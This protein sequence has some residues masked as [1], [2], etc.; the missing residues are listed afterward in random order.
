MQLIT[1]ISRLPLRGIGA[2][3]RNGNYIIGRSEEM[4]ECL[5]IAN[6][7]KDQNC[8]VMILGEGGTGKEL[9]AKAIHYSG[10]RRNRPFMVLDGGAIAESLAESE[11]LGI[12]NKVATDVKGRLGKFE[13]AHRGTAFLDEIGNLDFRLQSRL[14]RVTEEC[15]VVRVGTHSPKKLDF[16][17]ISATN[18]DLRR[19]VRDGT[20]REDLYY[21]LHVVPIHIPP[22]RERKEDI[23]LLAEYF[24]IQYSLANNL[25]VKK[26]SPEAMATLI[27]YH[28]PGNVRELRNIIARTLALSDGSGI[29]PDDIPDEIKSPHGEGSELEA[30]NGSSLVNQLIKKFDLKDPCFDSHALQVLAENN[31]R[32]KTLIMAFISTGSKTI[33]TRGYKRLTGASASTAGRDLKVLYDLGFLRDGIDPKTGK[34]AKGRAKFSELNV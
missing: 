6:K 29:T 7:V 33:T 30:E 11:I 24:T 5:G 19:A 14:L 25:Q 10:N 15:E 31:E 34:P 9:I 1:E 4:Q 16:R 21:R 20:F 23:P 17:L 32:V 12:E 26:I 2:S 22:L 3:L 18:I 28:W 13:A 27:D 8:A